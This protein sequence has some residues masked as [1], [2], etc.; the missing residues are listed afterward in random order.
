V[1]EGHKGVFVEYYYKGYY[2]ILK[3]LHISERFTVSNRRVNDY[4]FTKSHGV[5]PQEATIYTHTAYESV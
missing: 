3:D 4:Y 1:R 5:V 2:I